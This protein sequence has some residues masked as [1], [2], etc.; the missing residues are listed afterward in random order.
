MSNHIG[1]NHPWVKNLPFNDWLNGTPENHLNA[2]HDKMVLNDIHGSD[3]TKDHLT[4]GWFVDDMAD[5]NQNNPF[6]K[7]YLIQNTIWWIEYAGIDGIREDTYPYVFPEFLS[8]W[9]E[10]ILNEYPHL[11]IVGEV[12]TGETAYLAPFQKGSKLNKNLDTNLP[13][14]TDFALQNAYESYLQGRSN[15][16]SIYDVIAKD[17]L[18][19]DSNNLLVFADN[20]DIPRVMFSSKENIPKVKLVFAHMLTARGIPEILYGTEIGI[21]G[22]QEHGYLRENFRGGFPDSKGTAFTEE[23]RTEKENDL[24]S[25]FKKLISI[26][27]KYSSLEEGTLKHLAPVDNVYIY[28]KENTKDNKKEKMLILLNGDNSPKNRYE[29][30]RKFMR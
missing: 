19:E 21:V 24:Y 23:G 10:Q 16:Y 20:H 5:M 15:L 9:A 28:T 29:Y 22:N 11:N 27:K 8:D 4:K 7:K 18:Y 30:H 6:L 3:I 2:W 13:V 17:Y 26:R 1:T 12:W 25:F 14:V